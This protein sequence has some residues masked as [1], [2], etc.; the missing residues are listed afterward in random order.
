M[1]EKLTSVAMG[2]VAVVLVYALYDRFKRPAAAGATAGRL[3]P[4]GYEPPRPQSLVPAY[5][6]NISGPMSPY[7]SMYDFESGQTVD[8]GAFEGK[9][10]LAELEAMRPL[11]GAGPRIG[12]TPDWM[13]Q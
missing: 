12:S 11:V 9:N 2:V 1:N 3:T 13:Y 7:T 10:Y 5:G 6:S 4:T 8:V